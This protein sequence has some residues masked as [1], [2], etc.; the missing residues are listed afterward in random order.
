[1]KPKKKKHVYF[2]RNEQKKCIIDLDIKEWYKNLEKSPPK[3]SQKE[4]KLCR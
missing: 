3:L 2:F 4:T 1:M